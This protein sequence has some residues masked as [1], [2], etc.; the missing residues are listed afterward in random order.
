MYILIRQSG[1]ETTPSHGRMN[2]QY[3]QDPGAS[4]AQWVLR[5]PA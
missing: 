3:D 4:A 1:W 5:W 2:E